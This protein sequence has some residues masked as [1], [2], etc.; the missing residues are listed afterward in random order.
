MPV[1]N[2]GIFLA[3]GPTVDLRK[4]GLGRLL[5]AFLKAAATREDVRIVIVCPQWSRR[6]LVALCDSEGIP[7]ATFDIV[8]TTGVP[9]MVRLYLAY[10]E[11]LRRPPRPSR[12]MGL[13]KRVRLVFARHLR[14]IER[15]I[16]TAR[17]PISWL[18]VS[19][20][21]AI[22]GFVLLLLRGLA[23]CALGLIRVLT[24]TGRK[25]RPVHKLATAVGRAMSLVHGPGEDKLEDRLYRRLEEAETERMRRKI[26]ELGNI[27]AWFCP[28]SFWP[29]F[30][31]ISRPGL[32]CVPDVVPVEF[33]G[34]F[35]KEPAL[36]KSFEIVERSIR[37]GHNFVAYSAR[38]KWNTLVD[39]Y[40]V[41]P[42]N[43]AVIPHAC[44][45]LSPS[46]KVTGFSDEEHATREYC[47]SLL[48]QA[49]KRSGTDTYVKGLDS[50]SL[51]FLFYASQFR[52]NK[53]LVMLVRAYEHLLRE[54]FIQ[55]KLILTGD[56]N[57]YLPLRDY[58]RS[59]G[60]E[61][62]RS[63]SA[64]FDHGGTRGVLLLGGSRRQSQPER[65]RM[66]VHPDR[67]ALPV[68][69]PPSSWLG[70]R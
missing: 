64:R 33:P 42:E 16:V 29:A 15:G 13:L 2:F 35:A 30:N 4:E 25:L 57:R 44:W 19:V 50:G 61:P 66:P 28:T 59:H 23:W 62:G 26:D 20:Y 7:P 47:E 41:K 53:N 24:W 10:L 3:Y 65:G 69:L 39:R 43:V 8:T 63:L 27:K 51:R 9:F 6:T 67:G 14:A 52:P 45:D 54:R 18:A 40:A 1:R 68:S 36:L 56:P 21:A 5:T 37:G 32:L 34:G 48:Q 17:N 49:L 31:R 70:S 60:L 55:H 38:I 58:V 46:I 22:L 12:L 11:R